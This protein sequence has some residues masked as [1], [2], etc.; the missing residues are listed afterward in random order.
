[1]AVCLTYS[2]YYIRNKR[3]IKQNLTVVHIMYK[4]NL[5]I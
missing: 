1:M 4:P 2:T 5:N 3:V